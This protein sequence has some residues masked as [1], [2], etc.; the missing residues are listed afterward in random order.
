MKKKQLAP[1]MHDKLFKRARSVYQIETRVANFLMANGFNRIDTPMIEYAGVFEDE[2]DTHNYHLFDK[3]GELLVVRP[4]V[5]QAIARVVTTTKVTLPVK[6]SYSGKVFRNHD[7]LKGLQNERT[8]AGIEIIGFDADTAIT[9]ALD[10]AKT[11]LTK[12]GVKDYRIELS[13]A[14]ILQTIFATFD[15]AQVSELSKCIK[16][17]SITGLT[18]FVKQNPSE[19]DAFLQALPRLFGPSERVIAEAK[20]LVSNPTILGNLT[21]IENLSHS[22]DNSTIDLG[23]LAKR[24]Y[25]TGVMFRVFSDKVPYAF[26]SGGRY[27]KLFERFDEK[28]GAIS[29]VGWALDVDAI[30]EEIRD[31]IIFDKNGGQEA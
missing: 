26:L 18:E 23:M 16:N 31:S 15:A 1:G 2:L 11:S 12:S 29:A 21:E 4:D 17:K 19:F 6:F 24:D 3:H 8:Q 9:E 20:K 5:T 28:A 22:F 25:Y 27:D 30:Y 14:G 13:H 10:L 7:E